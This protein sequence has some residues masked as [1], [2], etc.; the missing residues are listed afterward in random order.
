[1]GTTNRD[2]R[3]VS[4]S[5]WI[6]HRTW[7]R[8]RRREQQLLT[9][10]RKFYAESYRRLKLFESEMS[11]CLITLQRP[12][13]VGLLEI[14][15]K[16][17]FERHLYSTSLME[18]LQ[19]VQHELFRRGSSPYLVHSPFNIQDSL[20]KLS[21]NYYSALPQIYKVLEDWKKHAREHVRSSHYSFESMNA[22]FRVYDTADD[23]EFKF[24]EFVWV[25]PPPF[26]Y[27]LSPL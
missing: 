15:M 6:E 20:R 25:L 24:R 7:R 16:T 9:H 10:L 1:M 18:G 4:S 12:L 27:D 14:S 2:P 13:A 8:E 5:P 11:E 26:L 19:R 21:E 23:M 17:Y 3:I 22:W